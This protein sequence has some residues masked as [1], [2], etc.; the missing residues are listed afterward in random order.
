VGS[1]GKTCIRE[2]Q[3]PVINIRFLTGY[4]RRHLNAI[5][6]YI[7]TQKTRRTTIDG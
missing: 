5:S 7:Q 6:S 1:R 3:R 2:M 4:R